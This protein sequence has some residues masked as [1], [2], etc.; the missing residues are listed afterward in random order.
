MDAR[1]IEFLSMLHY[2]LGTFFAPMFPMEKALSLC[3]LIC[4]GVNPDIVTT[5]YPC[6]PM[7]I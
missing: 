5:F 1:R 7:F 2:L 4:L 6:T 3:S